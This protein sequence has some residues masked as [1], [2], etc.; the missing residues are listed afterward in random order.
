LPL[1]SCSN[2]RMDNDETDMDCGGPSCGPCSPGDDCLLDRDC[3][4]TSTGTLCPIAGACA[5]SDRACI[6]VDA[7]DDGIACTRDFCQAATAGCAAED[8]DDDFDDVTVCDGDCDDD[9]PSIPRAPV[10]CD[11]IDDD[12]DGSIDEGTPCP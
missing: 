2:R 9:D 12:C 3:T 4:T 6:E 11:T 8:P 5:A 10:A 7:C 1:G